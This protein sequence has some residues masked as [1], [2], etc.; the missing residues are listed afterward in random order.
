MDLAL[1]ITIVGTGM[2]V[3]AFMYTFFRNFKIDMHNEIANIKTVTD[4]LHQD[5]QNAIIRIDHLYKV[6][7]DMLK[8]DYRG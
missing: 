6:I 4:K 2:G 8:K 5:H 1:F 3:I 7:I